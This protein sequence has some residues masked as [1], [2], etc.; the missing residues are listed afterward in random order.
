[1][2][3]KYVIGTWFSSEV[4]FYSNGDL[5]NTPEDMGTPNVYYN[6]KNKE[7]IFNYIIHGSFDVIPY[8]LWGNTPKDSTTIIDRIIMALK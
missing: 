8:M 7:D 3:H 1:M 5:N 6:S 4:V 2:N